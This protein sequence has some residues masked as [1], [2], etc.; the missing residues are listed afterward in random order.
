MRASLIAFCLLVPL[1]A[2]L[3]G[4]ALT[5]LANARAWASWG[6]GWLPGAV[7]FS[8][9]GGFTVEPCIGIGVEFATCKV[10]Y[11]L[12]LTDT[13][14]QTYQFSVQSSA[15]TSSSFGSLSV[16]ASVSPIDLVNGFLGGAEAEAYASFFD[17]LT[18]YSD[19]G[20]GIMYLTWNGPPVSRPSP[21]I[22]GYAGFAS[23][24]SGVPAPIFGYVAVNAHVGYP[25]YDTILINSNTLVLKE[26][27]VF[28]RDSNQQPIS[29]FTY[30]SESGAAYNVIGGT[31]VPE[32]SS[33]CLV[34]S[35]I[36]M[37]ICRLAARSPRRHPSTKIR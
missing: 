6:S 15:T 24:T 18:I 33:M 34:S 30:T 26:I 22:V 7:G 29:G 20:F 13:A 1:A 23:W 14:G 11:N 4:A 10:S 12:A 25:F 16:A 21:L 3:P 9:P 2:S 32:P 8:P 28:P 37:L 19:A 27:R 17:A 31:A 35:S 5:A 36:L